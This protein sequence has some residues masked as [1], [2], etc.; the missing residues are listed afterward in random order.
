MGIREVL[1]YGFVD[2]LRLGRLRQRFPECSINSVRVDPEAILAAGVA[3]AHDVEVRGNVSIGR[4]SYVEP[5]TFINGAKIGAFCAIGRN[6]AIG[7]FQHPYAYPTISPKL[8]R[9]ILEERYDDP[10]HRVSIGNDVWIGE[11]AIVLG[12]VIGDGAVIA[13][14]AVVT[15]D[16]EP[17]S[18]VA[19]VPAQEIRRRFDDEA[20]KALLSIR[21][22]EWSDEEIRESRELF[23]LREEWRLWNPAGSAGRKGR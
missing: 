19:G 17:Y 22:W 7:G 20:V 6:V 5:Y 4:W 18:I 16:V 9:S 1:R 15:K 11:K 2:G 10:P 13:A 12:G 14:G 23:S 21:W 3:I 8:Y